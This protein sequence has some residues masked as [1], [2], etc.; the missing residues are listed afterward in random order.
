M[1]YKTK[2]VEE[3][4]TSFLRVV[5]PITTVSEA[6]RRDHWA[7]KARR[8]KAH[9]NVAWAM[10]PRY[11]VPCIVTLTRLAPRILDDDNLRGALK[12][13]RDGVADRLGVKD[14]SPL[15]EWRYAQAKGRPAAV[16]V[17]FAEK[18]A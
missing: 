9:R 3:S 17:E 4:S 14:N 15:V 18:A 2:P 6:N 1:T 12:S 8:A 10:C 7:T 5:L 13:T 16:V 11:P